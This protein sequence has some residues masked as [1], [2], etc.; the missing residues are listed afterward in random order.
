MG[1][2]LGF[3]N[4]WDRW[5]GYEVP[6]ICDFPKCNE[7][8]DRGLEQVCG[9]TEPHGG[10]MGCGLHFCSKHH[11]YYRDESNNLCYRCSRLK[12]PFKPKPES[13]EWVRHLMNDETWQEWR[14]EKGDGYEKIATQWKKINEK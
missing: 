2:G 11:S 9:D 7:S 5:I 14:D 8:I 6:A 1:W 12:N 13:D 4:T 10:E 3:S